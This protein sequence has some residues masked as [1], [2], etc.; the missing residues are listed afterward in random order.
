MPI[1]LLDG[2]L[3]LIMFISAVLA[4]IRGFTREVF[5]IASWV[6]AAIVTYMFWQDVLPYTQQYVDDRTVALGLTVAGIFFITLIVVSLVTM[7]ISDF[8]LDS[9]AGPLDRTFGFVFGAA[10]GL[11][12]VV[13]AVLF[14]NFFISPE[15]QPTWIADARSKPWLDSMGQDL[16]NALPEDPEAEIIERFRQEDAERRAQP[17]GSSSDATGPAGTYDADDQNAL[18]RQLSQ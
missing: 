2:V 6:V 14:L 10:R 4:M 11:L 12:L 18:N 7:R 9:K 1:T 3:L 8:I 17:A 16:M 5:S 13:I 15:H